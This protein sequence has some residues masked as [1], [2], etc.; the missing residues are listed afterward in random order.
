[1]DDDD[2]RQDDDHYEP[3]PYDQYV[4]EGKPLADKRHEALA[5]MLAANVQAA[6]A[7]LAAFGPTDHPAAKL[8]ALEVSLPAFGRRVKTLKAA[9]VERSFTSAE[10]ID[11][12]WVLERLLENTRHAMTGTP[13]TDK[14]G[15]V[16]GHKYDTGGANTSLKL[17]GT[18]IGN[19]FGGAK[20]KKELD[21]KTEEEL[22]RELRE[23]R[24]QIGE[25]AKGNRDP[26]GDQA[27]QTPR[28][29]AVPEAS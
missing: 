5:Q 3:F 12:V 7:Y 24:E 15:E 18:Y 6:T 27:A 17:I 20:G 4:L 26:S 29:Q 1:M 16:I 22:A 2:Q 9:R 28:L 25:V 8:Y 21:E 14:Q 10:G 19:M 23:L 13:I 11:E